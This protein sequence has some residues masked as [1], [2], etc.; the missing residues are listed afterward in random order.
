MGKLGGDTQIE[1]NIHL[2]NLAF[3][4]KPAALVPFNFPLSFSIVRMRS[5]PSL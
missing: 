3:S 4:E 1:K 2:Y 5:S